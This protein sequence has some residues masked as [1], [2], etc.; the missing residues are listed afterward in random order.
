MKARPLIPVPVSMPVPK[1][2]YNR[3]RT[4]EILKRLKIKPEDV[5]GAPPITVLFE[6]AEG[7]LDAVLCAMRFASQD[8][9]IAEFLKKYDSIPSSDRKYLSWEAI[10]LAAKLD[11]HH[12]TGSILFA[13]EVASVNAVKIMALTSHPAVMQAT[14]A[15]A[16]LASGEKDRMMIHQGLRFLPTAKPPT[17]IGKAVFGASGDKDADHPAT[18]DEDDDLD[19][20]FPPPST[21]QEKLV[22]IRQKMLGN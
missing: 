14:I 12:L 16:M 19:D 11:L 18:F 21:M 20:L 2:L 15:S 6:Q 5:A 13:I 9:V 8:E 7:G 4:K 1:P 17:F 22:P 10:A 3:N